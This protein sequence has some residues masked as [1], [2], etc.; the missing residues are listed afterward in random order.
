MRLLMD[1]DSPYRLPAFGP[2][3]LW[4]AVL[5]ILAL[6][7]L[8]VAGSLAQAQLWPIAWVHTGLWAVGVLG[9]FLGARQ[10]RQSLDKQSQ[11][12]LEAKHQ[13]AF[14]RCNPNPVL[15]LS[16]AG[17]ISYFNAATGEMARALGLANA[18]QMLPP[19]SPELVR[20]CLATG[21]PKLCVE[22]QIGPRVISWSFFPV[23]FSNMV[24]CYGGDITERKRAE[25]ALQ[26]RNVLLS[27]QQEASLDGVL[28]VDE[29]AR[30]LSYNRR[31]IEIWGLPAKLVAAKA[32]EPVLQ[33]VTAQMQ[34]PRSFLQQAQY[35]YEH[36]QE[37]SRDELILADGR[38]L[39]RYSAPI[40]GPEE[41]YYGRVWYMRDITERKRADEALRR[42]N[43]LLLRTGELAKVG[44][45][46]LDLQT[47]TLF[48]SLETC[49]IHEVD[50]PIAPALDQAINFYAPEARPVIQAAVQAGIDSG[51]PFDLDLPL[52]TANGRPIW[53]R[54]QGSAVT[55]DGKA[56]KLLGAFQ[57]ITERRQ[58]EAALR[59]SEAKFRTL[60]DSTSD[61]VML[62]DQKGFFDCNQA[63]LAMFGCR[64]REEFCSKHP[65][66]MSPPLQPDGTDSL[67]LAKQRMAR[68]MEKGSYQFEWMHKRIDTGETFPAE[69]LL[70]ALELDGKRVLQGSVRDI[71]ER[72]RSEESLRLQTAA[73]EAAANGV[74]ITDPKGTILWVNPAFTQLT[75]YS[76]EE[77]IG[78][79][80]RVLKSGQHPEAYYKE[81]W[82][83]ISTGHVWKGEIVNRRKDGQLY[84]EEMTITPV[85]DRAGAVS[86]FVAIKQDISQRKR[87][88]EE[89]CKKEQLLSESQ[90]LGHIG[91]WFYDIAGS[92]SWSEELYRLFGV[93]PDTCTPSLESLLG[94]IHPDD[95]SSMQAW[96]AA[97]AAG[98]KPGGL[99]FRINLP[100]GTSRFILG[101]GQAVHDAGN[102]LMHMAGTA[103]DITERKRAQAE[104]E[105]LHK[106]LVDASRQAGME[107]VATNVL[108]N[109][110][111]VLNSVNISTGLIVESVRKS[112]ASSLARVVVLLREH[113]HDLG[114]F[115]TNDSRGKHVPAHLA[116]LSEHLLAEQA[117]NVRELDSLRRNVELIKQI[118]AMQQNYASFGG[119]K[120]MINVADLVEDS[121]R[122]IAGAL[123]RHDVEVIR[124]FAPVPPMNVEKHKVLQIMV[125]L[126]R[127][128]K[129][130]CQESERA[131]KRLT[132]R[133]GNGEGRIRI[134]VIDNGVGIPPE[135]LTRIFNHGFTTR[136]AGHGFGLHS[137]ALAAKEMGG[138]LA[139]H[140]DGPDQG[141]A[142]TL[143]LPLPGAEELT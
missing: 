143:E 81:L 43:E 60:Y 71:T 137:G 117:A 96:I 10:M 70:C 72:K 95:R 121:L 69:V 101:D 30:I 136:K 99:E 76:A 107:E 92:T 90:R 13:A 109:V 57:D 32:D 98:E 85:R 142:F 116:Q 9:I 37:T 50:P 103:Q 65:A 46:E 22:T 21:K 51:A 84:D 93:S 105:N 53:V 5:L 78:Q 110:G 18:A 58:A 97:C 114:E 20:E 108:H 135:N 28:M 140:S 100:D 130:A 139:V 91:S 66:D 41:R 63:A 24:H 118:V 25:E 12:E 2:R 126:L 87:A 1:I 55:A 19:S 36:R 54:A 141:A 17:D 134:S 16:A 88:E 47:M 34:D 3:Q 120:E 122:L 23:K 8:A 133:V 89:L 80:P 6:W 128:A 115:I 131:D 132:V 15:E 62:S 38:I 35:L 48:W 39:D 106:Q 52:T 129:H 33:F 74:A 83:T 86:H 82:Q 119:V 94:L 49:R 4:R 77:V 68:A 102:R 113:A 112:R 45:W 40:F 31:F 14:P 64:T 67:T 138:S 7:T 11:A 56:V 44:G 79:N 75:G 29:K 127:N 42:A 111:N 61:A 124:E 123:S 27:A 73:L 26:V 59:R 125:N 104:L